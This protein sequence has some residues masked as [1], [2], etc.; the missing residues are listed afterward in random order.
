MNPIALDAIGW[1]Y[2]IVFVVVLILYGLTAYFCY[3]ETKGM[4]LERIALIFDGD[5][6]VPEAASETN[7]AVEK[8]LVRDKVVMVDGRKSC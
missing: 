7:M 5:D 1:R 6:V 4:T 8:I 3:P 2:Y